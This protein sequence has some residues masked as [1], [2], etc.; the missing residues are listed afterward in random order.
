MDWIEKCTFSVGIVAMARYV[1][2]RRRDPSASRS[3]H[4][5]W[6]TA[7]N[8]LKTGQGNRISDLSKKLG[9]IGVVPPGPL[10]LD[11]QGA[12]GGFRQ[13]SRQLAVGRVIGVEERL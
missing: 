1:K 3:D 7:S 13:V 5:R 6:L 11:P 12:F 2:S 8:R 9:E 4:T 10:D